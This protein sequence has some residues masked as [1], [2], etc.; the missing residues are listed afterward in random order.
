MLILL[1]PKDSNDL[2][3]LALLLVTQYSAKV[4]HK[5][6][7]VKQCIRRIT[8]SNPLALCA[9]HITPIL[10]CWLA[11]IS[12]IS[13]AGWLPTLG[14]WLLFLQRRTEWT[15]LSACVAKWVW[16]R[17]SKT[18]WKMLFET[19]TLTLLNTDKFKWAFAVLRRSKHGRSSASIMIMMSV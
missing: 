1:A 12:S 9:L 14:P 17:I 4:S 11:I 19:W 7:M 8:Q 18:V 13:V 6:L 2:L 15:A 16:R 5:S 3:A 10:L